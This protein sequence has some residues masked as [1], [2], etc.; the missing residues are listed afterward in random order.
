M[1]QGWQS[2]SL[3]RVGLRREAAASLPSLPVPDLRGNR[4]RTSP[5]IPRFGVEVTL[6]SVANPRIC[7]EINLR[8]LTKPGFRPE[9]SL[10][11][12]SNPRIWGQITFP[13]LSKPGIWGQSS[14]TTLSKPRICGKSR[15]RTLSKPDFRVDG[16]ELSTLHPKV[17]GAFTPKMQDFHGTLSL[18]PFWTVSEAPVGG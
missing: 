2:V 17:T 7:G 14:L 15:L 4:S 1:V 11:A 13:A 6:P 3:P 9:V 10:P 16:T 12:L 8:A 5:R 18:V